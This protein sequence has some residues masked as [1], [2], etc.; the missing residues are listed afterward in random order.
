MLFRSLSSVYAN[1]F[2][3]IRLRGFDYLSMQLVTN[4]W[5]EMGAGDQ[6][7]IEAASGSAE[8]YNY[9]AMA[10]STI[11]GD[12]SQLVWNMSEV[13]PTGEY[14]LS[15]LFESDSSYAT[16][17]IHLDGFTMFA[18]QRVPQYTLDVQCDDPLPNAYIVVPAD[19]RPPSLYCSIHNNGYVDI[20]LR[21]YTEVSNQSWMWENPL[22][23]DSNHPSDHDN[24]V[25]T[26]VIKALHNM[27]AWFNLTIPDGVTVQEVDWYVHI[28]D[29]ITNFTKA[30]MTLAV[31]VT[32]AYSA[33]LTQKTLKNPAATL[34]PGTS[35][36]ITM[37]L[38]NTGKI[39]RASC[40]E[41]V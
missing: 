16:Q 27:D 19:S 18:I 22:R 9:T 31:D 40:R 26:K 2:C 12:W 32:A 41:R 3:R 1:N 17:G 33:Y 28:G 30:E 14:T 36:N 21:L 24:S 8:Y 37:T 5:G 4:A 34:L 10:L 20:T 13:H 29:G 35:G 39:G 7:R 6:I 15:F 38:K 11:Y 25:V 23:I